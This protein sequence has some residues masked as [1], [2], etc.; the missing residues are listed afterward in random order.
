MTKHFCDKCGK[1]VSA[2]IMWDIRCDA[3]DTET[4]FHFEICSECMLKVKNFLIARQK[5]EDKE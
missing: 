2:P 5:S 1:E 3:R 4:Y